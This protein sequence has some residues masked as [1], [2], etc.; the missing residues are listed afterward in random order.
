MTTGRSICLRAART[1]RAAATDR[2]SSGAEGHG[3]LG[4]SRRRLG[5]LRSARDATPIT[6]HRLFGLDDADV[7]IAWRSP[8]RHEFQPSAS[9]AGVRA[10]RRDQTVRSGTS[11]AARMACMVKD[12]WGGLDGS[13]RRSIPAL[14]LAYGRYERANVA[15][16]LGERTLSVN[17]QDDGSTRQNLRRSIPSSST[18]WRLTRSATRCRPGA[19]AHDTAGFGGEVYDGTSTPSRRDQSVRAR[20]SRSV[21]CT[22]TAPAHDYRLFVQDQSTSSEGTTAAVSWPDWVAASR[23]SMCERT[24][25]QSPDT[26]ESLGVADSEQSYRLDV[27]RSLTWNLR[28]R[29]R[30]RGRARVPRPESERLGALG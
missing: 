26:G 14:Q 4:A 17:A 9:M 15:I 10:C 28:A 12:L 25:C 6:L 20:R 11:G 18:T 29:G 23:A 13:S 21:R 30:A 2:C 3:L 16:R 24:R 8:A 22:P 7:G 5:D 27:Q 1:N 19:S